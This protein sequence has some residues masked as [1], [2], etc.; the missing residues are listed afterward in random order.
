VEVHHAAALELRHL[1][2]GHTDPLARR[3][4][5]QAGLAGEL[6]LDVGA[7]ALEQAAR[8]VV[9]QRAALVVEAVRADRLAE[10]QVVLGVALAAGQRA[11]VQAR[12]APAARTA[13][14]PLA[15]GLADRVHRAEARRR[16][17]REHERMLGDRLGHAFAAA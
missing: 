1:D 3:L 2:V 13:R 15:A 14:Q 8:V 4:L 5:R 10:A 6:A 17:G 16:E 12:L 11:A 7:R 9:P